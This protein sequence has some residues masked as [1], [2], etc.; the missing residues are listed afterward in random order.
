MDLLTSNRTSFA[1]AD[2]AGCAET[3]RSTSG[4]HLTMKGPNSDFP[5]MGRSG[6]QGS[7]A[8]STPEAELVSGHTAVKNV[9]IPAM[10]L[11]QTILLSGLRGVFHEDNTAMI[12]VVQMNQ[13]PTVKHLNRVHGI[14]I[15][16]LHDQLASSS[17]KSDCDLIYTDSKEMAADIYTKAFT[18]AAKWSEVCGHIGVRS[19]I[20]RVRILC[21]R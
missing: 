5:I 4:A 16:F 19:D 6:R 13:N 14:A 17:S 9:L 8:S 18:D 15:S 3:Q 21:R 1:D 12:R 20:S 2:L 11:W 10:D 7:C